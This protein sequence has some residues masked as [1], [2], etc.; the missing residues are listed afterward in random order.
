MEAIASGW[1]N[2]ASKPQRG[3]R[4]VSIKGQESGQTS[5]MRSAKREDAESL[6]RHRSPPRWPP[7]PRMN[8]S[9]DAD[10]WVEGQAEPNQ[11]W[12]VEEEDPHNAEAGEEV[13]EKLRGAERHP[14][15]NDAAEPERSLTA[16]TPEP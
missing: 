7:T 8:G 4:V 2:Q 12:R 11:K 1:P 9:H 5:Y 6:K 13:P 3:A 16:P 14:E 10:A 15:P